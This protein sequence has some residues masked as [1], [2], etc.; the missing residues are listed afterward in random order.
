MFA[1]Q[2]IRTKLILLPLLLH[3]SQALNSQNRLVQVWDSI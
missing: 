1:T 3:I 2:A